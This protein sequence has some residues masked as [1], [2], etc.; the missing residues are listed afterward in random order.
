VKDPVLVIVDV[1]DAADSGPLSGD[2]VFR[3]QIGDNVARY[4]CVG[5]TIRIAIVQLAKLAAA[6]TNTH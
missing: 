6:V 4:P 2:F 3:D 1:V 5:K